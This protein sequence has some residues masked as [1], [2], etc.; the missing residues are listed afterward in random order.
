MHAK[1]M[2][3]RVL[4]PCLEGLHRKR[5]AALMRATTGLFC[6]GVGSL[7]G[8]ALRLEGAT[9]YKHRLKSVDRLLGSR[10]LHQWRDALYRQVAGLWLRDLSRILV[11]VDWT[12][13][14]EDQRWQCLRASVVVQGRSI[15]LYEQVH[16]QN[17][18]GQSSGA[19]GILATPG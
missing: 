10:A 4:G 14:S 13:L 15:T 18:V 3:T 11:V 6:G 12:D 19:P 5:F 17:E 9:R 8:I 7:S 1:L 16:P 2:V